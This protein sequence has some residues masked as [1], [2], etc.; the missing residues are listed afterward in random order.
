[1]AV[2][3]EDRAFFKCESRR[4]AILRVGES[5]AGVQALMSCLMRAE[6]SVTKSSWS[7]SI[8][9]SVERASSSSLRSMRAW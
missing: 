4:D 5:D 6:R 7:S 8:Y 2:L 3:T 1:M 9:C